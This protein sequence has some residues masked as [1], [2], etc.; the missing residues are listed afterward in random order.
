VDASLVEERVPVIGRP[1]MESRLRGSLFFSL[2]IIT[3][4]FTANLYLIFLSYIESQKLLAVVIGGS[5]NGKLTIRLECKVP[6]Y[7]EN[8][9]FTFSLAMD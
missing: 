7:I 6:V 1:A 8:N 3:G 2:P 4:F 9:T 5:D